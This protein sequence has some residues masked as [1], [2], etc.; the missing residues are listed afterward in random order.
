MPGNLP[1]LPS[2]KCTFRHSGN[3]LHRNPE[4]E[5]DMFFEIHSVQSISVY[6]KNGTLQ[7]SDIEAHH[8]VCK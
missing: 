5:Q 3:M 1:E 7:V 2:T 4:M 8:K 6:L